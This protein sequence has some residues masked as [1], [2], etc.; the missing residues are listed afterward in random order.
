MNKLKVL[1]LLLSIQ[2][3]S[4]LADAQVSDPKFTVSQLQQDYELFTRALKEAHPGLYRYTGKDEI[5]SLFE[6][7][8]SRIAEPMSE[9]DFYKLLM[10]IIVKIRCGHTKWFRNEKTDDRYAFYNDQLFP[11][12]L[13]FLNDKAF[14]IDDYSGNASILRGSEVLTING[15]TIPQ[16]RE[17]IN[18]YIPTDGF[19]KSLLYEELNHFFNGYFATFVDH[20]PAYTV[21]LNINKKT[22][23]KF[24]PGVALTAIQH[25]EQKAKV[26]SQLPLRLKYLQPGTALLTIGRFFIP[27]EEQ[28]FYAFIDSAFLDLKIKGVENLIIDVRNNEGGEESFGGYLYSYLAAGDFQY[29]KKI[30]VAQKEPVTFIQHAWMP[31]PYEEERK[32]FVE[33]DGEV[34]WMGQPYLS[35]KPAQQNAFKGK[36]FVLI[37]GLSFSVTSEFASFVHHHK[38]ATFI[39]EET[40]GAYYGNNSG[41]FTI[42]TLPNTKLGMGIPLL[43]FYSNVSGYP[44]KDRGIIPNHE[45]RRTVDDIIN[46]KD[47]VLEFTLGLTRSAKRGSLVNK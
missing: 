38:R 13:Y 44:Y 30:T 2:L 7:T 20:Q 41:V 40:G 33:K 27:K 19:V 17:Q 14:V 39:G 26:G 8:K 47:A 36:V 21:T 46:G 4:S 22:V 3:L 29:Y 45:V 18:R 37:N 31:P 34:L 10:P 28:D 43:G 32:K 12:K 25:K 1:L 24:L 9:I 35:L 5:D 6:I 11:L 42:V 15:K 16:I 23:T